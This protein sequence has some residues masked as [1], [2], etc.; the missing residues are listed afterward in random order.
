[1]MIADYDAAVR[2]WTGLNGYTRWKASEACGE[3]SNVSG[4]ER[5]ETPE[6][7]P[8]GGSTTV[9]LGPQVISLALTTQLRRSSGV[10]YIRTFTTGY[11]TSSAV[12]INLCHH[13]HNASQFL[14]GS[15]H[16]G[17]FGP[18]PAHPPHHPR[19]VFATACPHAPQPAVPPC[20]WRLGPPAPLCATI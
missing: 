2:I 18:P 5:N 9:P 1:M 10:H 12:L 19:H 17:R 14:A 11:I 8:P 16:P 4:R 7:E 15:T 20:A 13:P 6:Q 3:G